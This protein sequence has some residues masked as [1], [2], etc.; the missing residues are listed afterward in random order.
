MCKCKQCLG[1]GELVS[2]DDTIVVEKCWYCDGTGETN[3]PEEDED[4]EIFD[5]N[6]DYPE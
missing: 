2:E 1:S 6:S 4:D 5:E 3:G